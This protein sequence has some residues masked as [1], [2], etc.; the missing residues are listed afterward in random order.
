MWI[1][2]L[3]SISCLC[4]WSCRMQS[5][6]CWL[7][8]LVNSRLGLATYHV[9]LDRINHMLQVQ[10]GLKLILINFTWIRP[11]VRR[12][13]K[14]FSTLCKQV[15]IYLFQYLILS[16]GK[17]LTLIMLILSWKW[18]YVG[19]I[20]SEICMKQYLRIDSYNCWSY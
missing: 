2:D 15:M 13:L 3:I 19:S 20:S 10:L 1:C 11:L 17:C 7:I 8:Y 4:P 5:A 14:A 18:I 16:C 9:P 12:N 6:I